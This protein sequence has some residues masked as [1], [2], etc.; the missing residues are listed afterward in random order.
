M[1]SQTSI[2]PIISSTFINQMPGYF[3]IMDLQSK[4]LVANNTALKW[5]GFNSFDAITGESY[6]NMSCEASMQHEIF[7]Q[8][9]RRVIYKD[10]RL[11][12]LSYLCC[13]NS[14]WKIILGEKYPIRNEEDQIIGVACHFNDITS[15]GL[16][17][18]NRFFPVTYER[19]GV[20]MLKKSTVYELKNTYP[21]ASLSS[22]LAECI[23][24]LLR[25]KTVKEIAEILNLS[26]RTAE[27]YIDDI[28]DKMGCN[29]KSELIEKCLA[30]GYMNIIPN[31]FFKS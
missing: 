19:Y 1:K 25:G 31:S 24:F 6:G 7:A 9:D 20:R 18:F 4:F 23:F 17:D 11:R 3:A 10:E 12:L 21:D 22:R 15:F 26:K 27:G 5:A 13:A 8:Q 14:D 29:S 30:K 28:K 16:I 2:A